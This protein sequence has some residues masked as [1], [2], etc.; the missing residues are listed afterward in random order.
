MSITAYLSNLPSYGVVIIVSLVL[1]LVSATLAYQI[2]WGI[3]K[4]RWA[5]KLERY[6][7]DEKND[8][9]QIRRI[10]VAE[11][12]IVPGDLQVKAGN[13]P[14][15]YA[16]VR[17]DEEGV[18]HLYDY[19]AVEKKDTKNIYRRTNFVSILGDGWH[20][21]FQDDGVISS[22]VVPHEL[23]KITD[24]FPQETLRVITIMD[25]IIY[26]ERNIKVDPLVHH[27]EA[28]MSTRI[29]TPIQN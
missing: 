24:A 23:R 26:R 21:T 27:N 29:I 28:K 20:V 16:Y 19:D 3:P 5:L 17:I 1:T 6:I 18:L 9:S 8:S 22:G 11:D 25:V 14:L 12:W 2:L 4:N 15:K 7:C 10:W 13:I